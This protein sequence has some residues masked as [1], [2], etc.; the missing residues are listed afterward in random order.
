MLSFKVS[1][2]TIILSDMYMTKLEEW[3]I[4]R[5]KA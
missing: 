1:Y 4:K 2:R 3:I 5:M